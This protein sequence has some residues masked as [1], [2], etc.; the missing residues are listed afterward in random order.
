MKTNYPGALAGCRTGWFQNTTGDYGA[1]GAFAKRRAFF[2]EGHLR[3]SYISSTPFDAGDVGK[4]LLGATSGDQGVI[5]E[6]DSDDVW[7]KPVN[8]LNHGFEISETY[9]VTAGVG[10]GSITSPPFSGIPPLTDT[11]FGDGGDPYCFW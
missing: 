8:L 2:I 7:V 10:A 9:T 3:L 4:T 6:F 11:K 5:A 1:A